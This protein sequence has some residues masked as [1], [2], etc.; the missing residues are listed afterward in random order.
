MLDSRHAARMLATP[1]RLTAALC[2]LLGAGAIACSGDDDGAST[3]VCVG[4]GC[5]CEEQGVCVCGPSAESDAGD[6]DDC[7]TTCVA[8]CSL[9]CIGSAKCGIKGN[10]PVNVTCS[11][12]AHCKVESDDDT[13]G[14]RSSMICS[15]RSDCNFKAGD[16]A[17]ATCE[18]DAHCK[19]DLGRGSQVTC[20]D[21]A[22]CELKCDDGC[23]VECGPDATCAVDCRTADGD[24]PATECDDGRFLCGADC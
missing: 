6:G 20:R 22:D 18:D 13:L 3:A 10:V 12:Q 2:A 16:D 11:D 7:T 21:S 19:L 8:A 17:I 4:P 23:E 15:A 9:S 14:E 1:V 5:S 24:A